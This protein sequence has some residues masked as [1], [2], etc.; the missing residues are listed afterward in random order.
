M[1]FVIGETNMKVTYK[2]AAKINLM[3][4]IISRLDN[5]YHSLFMIMQSVGLYDTVTAERSGTD[6]EITCD[7]QAIPCNES[8][9]AFKAAKLFF[10]Y[11]G[12]KNAAV[13]IHIQKNIPF[14]AG[15]AG[16]SA[17]AAA[18][19]H[20]LNDLY[21]A[22][23]TLRELESIG[24]KVGADVPFC[25]SGG[26]KLA[27]NIGEVLSPLPEVKGCF[28]VLV[29]PEQGVSTAEAYAQFD[30]APVRH[31]DTSGMLY[32]AANGD[33]EAVFSKVGNVFEQLVE[34]P[35]RVP[36]KTVMYAH[37][38]KCACMSGSGPTVFG[39]FE[40]TE[41]AQAAADE[42][43]KDFKQV[44]VCEPVNQSVI[45]VVE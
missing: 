42:L 34:V 31:L 41:A 20:A 39:V 44:F 11:T 28:F 25:L 13:K 26:T 2:A 7:N 35:Q 12:E 3:L 18:V 33:F 6:I 10:D 16:G 37:G 45:K 38:A 8:N 40:T 4:D 9:T 24:V 14:A 29:K 23:L 43:K 5:G 30:K 19:L 27:Q 22:N 1:N 36:I 17:D 32:S 21:N 15:L